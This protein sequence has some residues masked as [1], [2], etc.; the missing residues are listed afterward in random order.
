MVAHS[1]YKVDDT[2]KTIHRSISLVLF[3]GTR[4]AHAYLG[5][6]ERWV[7]AD[8]QESRTAERR[9]TV[10]DRMPITRQLQRP[11][12]IKIRSR[13]AVG[14]TPVN[15]DE[16]ICSWQPEVLMKEQLFSTPALLNSQAP[17]P[18][19]PRWLMPQVL[20]PP[21]NSHYGSR[22]FYD[23]SYRAISYTLSCYTAINNLL[24]LSIPCFWMYHESRAGFDGWPWVT[25]LFG[26]PLRSPARRNALLIRL[27]FN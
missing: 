23:P 7:D 11:M 3:R 2:L 27:Q 15:F 16:L 17:A 14:G 18:Q 6:S 1:P 8:V 24:V 13:I 9:G 19:F 12:A 5:A 20:D 10:T 26:G 22:W 4:F 21:A 25:D